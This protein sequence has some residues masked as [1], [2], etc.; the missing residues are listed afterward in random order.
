MRESVYHHGKRVSYSHG[1]LLRHYEQTKKRKLHINQGRRTIA[2]QTRF[3]NAWQRFKRGGPP[4]PLAAFPA[5]GAPHIKNGKEHHALDI[6]DG[7]VDEVAEFYRELDVPVAFNVPG[8]PWHMDTLDEAKLISAAAK[9]VEAE[10]WKGYTT[11]EKRWIEEYDRLKSEDRDL[12]RRRV[13]RRVMT[14]QRQS[15]WRQAQATG[16]RKN[17]R[18]ARYHSLKA[19]TS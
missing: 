13:L 15:I 16:W 14:R 17:N 9:I 10:R 11:T 5:P 1:V 19:R 4:A 3:W 7:V 2:E 12:P 6:D 18:S 8:E